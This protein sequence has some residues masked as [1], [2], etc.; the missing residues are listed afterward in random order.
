MDSLTFLD[1]TRGKLQS[2]YVVHGDEDFLKRQVFAALKARVLGEE[3]AESF[4]LA[5]YPGE[6]AVWRDVHDE[7]QTLPFLSPRRL[8]ILE[9]AEPFV[10]AFRSQLEKYVAAPA[11]NGVLVLDLKNWAGNTKLSKL[12]DAKAVV[13]CKSLTGPKLAAWC[14]QWATAQ[15]GK[16]LLA[17]AAQL[18]VDLVGADMG[19]LSQEIA[20][21]AVYV[22]DTAQIAPE[23]VDRL[24]G[25]NRAENT[26]KIFDMVGRGDA[27]G[28]LTLLDRLLGQGDEPL[29]LLGAFGWQLRRLAQATR[30]NAL[31]TPLRQALLEVGFQEFKLRDCEQQMRHLGRRRLERLYD[32]LLEVDL[33]LKGGSQLPPRILL[34]RLILR[35]A[36]PNP[37]TPRPAS[38]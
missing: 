7:L 22:G 30:L 12:I 5:V 21:L 1:Q 18:L 33:G 25:N 17:P 9:N 11:P 10:T 15:H 20:K 19:L 29:R 38:R 27:A 34:E 37:G 13:T 36:V 28:A 3:A 23:D 32:W 8:V 24:V 31:G 26:F 16:D 35:L 2:V 14:R 4:A 6:K